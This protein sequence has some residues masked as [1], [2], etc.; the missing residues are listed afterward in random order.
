MVMSADLIQEPEEVIE[1]LFSWQTGLRRSH[2]A[3]PP[4]ADQRRGIAG[5][6]QRPRHGQIVGP[7][8]LGDRIHAPRVAS[9]SR[10]ALMLA[11]HQHAARRGAHG[12]TRIKLGEP[13]SLARHA[14]QPRGTDDLLP[15]A[16]QFAIAEVI[17]Q[18]PDQVGAFRRSDRIHPACPR[19]NSG[20][21]ARQAQGAARHV[22]PPSLCKKAFGFQIYGSCAI[23][24]TRCGRP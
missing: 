24:D 22:R 10:A 14:V 16:A 4:F 15:V 17:R 18:H 5:L 3:Q 12:R 8:S 1:P 19:Q 13:H 9:H 6:L 21:Q 23:K 7:Q 20:Q 2:V 11:G